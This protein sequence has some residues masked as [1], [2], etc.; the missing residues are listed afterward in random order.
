VLFCDVTGSTAMAEQ[1]DPEEWADIMN[2]AFEY[3]TGPVYRYEGTVARLMG[4]AILAF[5]GAPTSHEDDPQRA[6]LAGLDIVSSIAPF[7]EQIKQEYGFDFDVR[8]GIN[9]GPV[10]V[11]DVGSAQ[12]SEYTAMGDAV[13]VAARM[14]QTA[15]PGT[16]QIAESTYN[17]IAPLFDFESLGGVEVKGKNEPVPSYRALNPKV[18]PGRLR[19]IEG[20]DSPLVGRDAELATL[21]E[22][23]DGA[24]Q[25]RGHIVTLI[26][27]AGLGKSRLMAEV[28][29]EWEAQG[30]FWAEGRGVAYDMNRPYGVF[31][32]LAHRLCGLDDSDTPAEAH[33]KIKRAFAE[34]PEDD[35]D[36][37][38]QATEMLLAVQGLDRPDLQ[39]D[40]FKREVFAAMRGIW[41]IAGSQCTVLVMDDIHW[42]D[43]ESTELLLH[44]VELVE[45]VPIVFIC[46]FRPDR[47]AN[48]WRFRQQVEAD[49]PHLY[50]EIALQPL[51]GDDTQALVDNLL[52]ISDLPVQARQLILEKTEG[53]PF[54]IEEV[55][56]TLID[57]GVVVRDESGEHWRATSAIENIAIPDNLQALL[58]SRIDRLDSEARRTLQVASVIGRS[59][60]YQV[61]KRVSDESVA[62][63]RQLSTLQRVELI[64]EAARVPDVEFMFR[65]ELTRQAAY[66]S[67]LRRSRPQFHRQVGEAME[68][69]FAGRLDEESHRLAYHFG[70]AK[71][72]DRALWYS[73]SAANNA[74]HLYANNEAVRHYGRALEIAERLGLESKVIADLATK[75]GRT[76]ELASRLDEALESYE[77]LEKQGRESGDKVLELAGIIPQGTLLALLNK[78]SDPFKA[79]TLS[80]YGLDLAEELDDPRGKA[81]TLWNLMLSC[82]FGAG[83]N[84]EGI[85][86]GERSIAIAREH[87]LKEELAYALNDINRP[88]FEEGEPEKA[89]AALSESASLWRELNNLPMLA[90][91]MDAMADQYVFMGRMEEARALLDESLALCRSIGNTWAEAVGVLTRSF[92]ELEAAEYGAALASTYEGEALGI[93]SSFMGIFV[94]TG[95]VRSVML[96]ALGANEEAVES[97]RSAIEHSTETPWAAAAAISGRLQVDHYSGKHEISED[98]LIAMID[99]TEALVTN[100]YLQILFNVIGEVLFAREMYEETLKLAEKTLALKAAKGIRFG[101]PHIHLLRG[102]SLDA[103]GRTAEAR[104]SIEDGIAVAEEFHLHRNL[105]EVY[106]ELAKHEDRSGEADSATKHRVQAREIVQHIARNAGTEAL[107][108]SFLAKPEVQAVIKA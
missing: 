85:E 103:L 74:A 81:K 62:L 90:D 46:A 107:T 17:L 98:E 64:R 83:T 94:F 21:R 28:R 10:V 102:K 40:A 48:S 72:D 34:F 68:E 49:F 53:N 70:E 65:H 16:V 3:L 88:Y 60:Y 108:A 89:A 39:G 42:A 19:G 86:F 22:I 87:G 23:L 73:V 11:G 31:F 7:R 97:S 15:T 51:K 61:L 20:L 100:R 27:E 66:D 92:M 77:A 24:V 78:L 25:G 13:N 8:M 45:E 58:I 63:D 80:Q 50:T 1:L 26:G 101:A 37:A 79:K 59:F 57:S 99:G 105:W 55:V 36:Q 35:R 93:Q 52:A 69:V 29:A 6:V 104:T 76:L 4:D 71:D 75:R 33:E 54:F 14:E 95:A 56:R 67:I 32:H 91:N 12:A 47:Q 106:A 41:R 96:G 9:T 5:F 30:R 43:A 84:A 2:E 38:V 82:Y 18:E 44:L